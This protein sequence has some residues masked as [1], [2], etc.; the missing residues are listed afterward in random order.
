[1]PLLCCLSFSRGRSR[2]EN[3][4]TL[5]GAQVC[6]VVLSRFESQRYTSPWRG[7]LF[8]PHFCLHFAVPTC[9]VAAC[10]QS[11]SEKV[12]HSLRAASPSVESWQF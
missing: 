2:V 6:I 9:A 5:T 1:M 10:S 3:I 4:S 7:W 8:F 12:T 11:L